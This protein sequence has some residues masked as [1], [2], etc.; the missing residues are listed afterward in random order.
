M[1]TFLTL[2]FVLIFI[3][4]AMILTSLY[5]A[6][7]SKSTPNGRHADSKISKIYPLDIS[8]SDY[9]KAV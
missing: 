4:I 1:T 6:N 8:T 5:S 7:K 9:K 3:N 2:V